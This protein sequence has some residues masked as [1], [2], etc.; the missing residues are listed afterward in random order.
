MYPKRGWE[1][2]ISHLIVILFLSGMCFRIF[3]HI[4]N[5]SDAYLDFVTD[6]FFYYFLPAK[7][8]ITKGI[9]S[10]DGI[11]LTN[12]YHPLWFV[13][14]CGLYIL[15]GGGEQLFFALL[16]IVS[17]L[18]TYLSFRLLWKLRET[19]FPT[20]WLMPSVILIVIVIVGGLSFLGMEVTLT[21]PLYAYLLLKISLLNFNSEIPTKQ[22][23][24]LGFISSLLILSRLDTG[25]L[26]V[27]MLILSLSIYRQ[28]LKNKFMF[29]V[30][31]AIGGIAVPL[32]FLSNYYWFGHLMTVS[33]ASKAL[34]DAHSINFGMI[35]Y[36]AENRDGLAGLILIPFGLLA[37]F[38]QRKHIFNRSH[39]LI[40]L[41]VLC[42]P[43]LYYFTV[44]FESDWF[45][46]RWYLYPLPFC[47][48]ISL[49]LFSNVFFKRIKERTC[50]VLSTISL[51]VA[52]IVIIVFSYSLVLRDTI[53]W[54]PE[55]N[56]VY[57]NAKELQP[58]VKE[59][60]GIYAMGDQAGL[61]A[62]ILQVPIIQLE[63]LNA[64]FHMYENIKNRRDLKN[65]LQEYHVDYLIETSD[66]FGLHKIDNCYNIE[67]PHTAQ[68][69]ALSYKMTGRF[70]EEP[71]YHN[72]TGSMG[73][74]QMQTDIFKVK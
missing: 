39:V 61:T 31:F 49:G 64:D 43:I 12:G 6:D 63:G 20:S 35:R 71:L 67:D 52:S 29:S 32:Y 11:T 54:K 7:D 56:S 57:V 5:S 46:N 16:A 51:A 74:Y 72:A 27:L 68:A 58:F 73:S 41:L 44:L 25:L 38:F 9:S 40:C 47:F 18:S 21:I 8:L 14:N 15:S 59:H 34:K 66:Q 26:I 36:L 22:I 30:F 60:P 42:Y 4:C 48:F 13:V 1:F 19:L 28:S 65:V 23:L 10:F 2:R 37:L 55:P 17:A 69:G 62:Y 33:S 3:Y 53:N 45:L 70:C 24:S 50:F